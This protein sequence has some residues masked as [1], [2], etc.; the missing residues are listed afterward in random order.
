MW[1]Y[2]YMDD[3]TRTIYY[4]ETELN[5]NRPDLIFLGMSKNPDPRMA[6]AVFMQKH[7]LLGGYKIRPL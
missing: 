7:L 2:Y 4:T 3:H 1:F 6:V 5:E